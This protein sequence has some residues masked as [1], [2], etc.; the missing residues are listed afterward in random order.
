MDKNK[1]QFKIILNISKCLLIIG[2]YKLY[3][4][5]QKDRLWLPIKKSDPNFFRYFWNIIFFS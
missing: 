3:K 2:Y 5:K 1:I 4:T